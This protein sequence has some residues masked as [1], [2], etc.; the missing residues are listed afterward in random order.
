MF[1]KGTKHKVIRCKYERK[2]ASYWYV[3][4]NGEEDERVEKY[5]ELNV[6][7][8]RWN[9]K[10]KIVYGTSSREYFRGYILTSNTRVAKDLLNKFNNF[11]V[12][13]GKYGGIKKFC[14]QEL[15]LIT[16]LETTLFFETDAKK[17][18]GDKIT[19]DEIVKE[20]SEELAFGIKHG[21]MNNFDKSTIEIENDLREIILISKNT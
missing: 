10:V 14:S 12:Y 15:T 3:E 8:G 7:L 16:A 1:N 17:Y 2:K 21:F 4:C 9:D 5:H 13:Q 18:L 11:L 20:L 19:L 6:D